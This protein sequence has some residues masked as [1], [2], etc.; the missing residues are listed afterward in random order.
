MTL[1]QRA[2]DHVE[3]RA[4]ARGL[5]RQDPAPAARAGL[6][7]EEPEHVA[8]DL[9]QP[10]ALR[11]MVG[12]VGTHGVDDSQCIRGEGVAPERVGTDQDRGRVMV[13]GPAKHH[14]VEA[15]I[16]KGLRL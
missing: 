14:T 13:G 16:E 1:G 4:V 3:T 11:Q 12:D 6:A 9:M 5:F 2:V 10:A 8:R 15:L 7:L